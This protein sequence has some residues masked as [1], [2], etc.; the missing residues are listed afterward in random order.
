MSK[1]S[2][3]QDEEVRDKQ[4]R[5]EKQAAKIAAYVMGVL[6]QPQDFLRVTVVRLWE[7]RFRV[8]VQT[9]FDAVSA[10]VAHSFFLTTDETGK[11]IGS[12]PAL[13]RLY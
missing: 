3:Q 13:T 1:S 4:Q 11:V 7:N 6:G 2:A 10:R 12:D 5:A 9:G 8:N